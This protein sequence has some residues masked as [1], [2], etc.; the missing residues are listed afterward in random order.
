M[1]SCNIIANINSN[2]YKM[3]VI[4]YRTMYFDLFPPFF[5]CSK[6]QIGTMFNYLSASHSSHH[7]QLVNHQKLRLL[8]D[9][10]LLRC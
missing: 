3:L 6:D 9:Q 1:W 4:G 10:H 2:V 5:D 8:C 7:L